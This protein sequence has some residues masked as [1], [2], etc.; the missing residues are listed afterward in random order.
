MNSTLPHPTPVTLPAAA[1]GGAGVS[2]QRFAPNPLSIE[3]A[4]AALLEPGVA[5][6]TLA[7][8][9]RFWGRPAPQGIWI[10]AALTFALGLC[11]VLG[12]R[13][14]VSAPDGPRSTVTGHTNLGLFAFVRRWLLV[15]AALGAVGALSDGL[16]AFPWMMLMFWALITPMAQ[17][18]LSTAWRAF[19]SHQ[20]ALAPA[21]RVV[22]IG[23]G[24]VGQRVAQTLCTDPNRRL[25]L[26]GFFDDR[27]RERSAHSGHGSSAPAGGS[28]PAQ[29]PAFAALGAT[30]A[31]P[32]GPARTVLGEFHEAAAFVEQQAVQ[33]VYICLP[34]SSQ[35]RM[36]QLLQRLQGT[37]AS[38]Y[39]VPDVFGIRIIHGRLQDVGGVPVLGLCDTPFSGLNATIK[40][41]SDVVLAS[42]ILVLIA[43]VMAAVAIGVKRSSPG[44]IL[45]KQRRNGLDGQEI[46]VYKFRSMTTQDNGPV[47]QQARRGD[48]R[49]TR[50]GAFIRR[51]SLDELPQFINVLQGRMS[52]VGP[53]P[54]A[55]AHNAQYRPLIQ[56]YMV[57]H[58]VK[59]GITGW[60]QV[61]GHRGETDTLDKMAAR[62]DYDLQYLHHW[63]LG[64]DLHIIWRTVKLMLFDRH[65]Y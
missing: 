6:L 7:A 47:V 46:L 60:A 36:M 43:P 27:Q 25:Q 18:G 55:V 61:N 10:L 14:F 37:T 24:P 26:L 65:A 50:F 4:V 64:L 17:W 5:V 15:L 59:P 54:H 41:A 8:A 49:I 13:S 35:P 20:Q 42:L 34:L 63:S 19:S 57:R 44:P 51:T 56:A 39:F 48:P 40:R 28:Q 21:Q 29:S 12:R 32:A 58:K 22:V 31:A 16:S 62:V 3:A 2:A 11:L 33:A 1:R 23:A 45:F 38:V 30:Q 53:R 52:I 9:H